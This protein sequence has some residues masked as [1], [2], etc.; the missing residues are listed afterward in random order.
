MVTAGQLA[1]LA[2]A[3]FTAEQVAAIVSALVRG[4]SAD[5]SGQI[6]ARREKDRKR[7][8]LARARVRGLS[9]DK[10]ST[11]PSLSK[12][13]I[14]LNKKVETK[15]H[16]QRD[17]KEGLG[18]KPKRAL[19]VDWTPPP[20]ALEIASEKG[21]SPLELAD[22]VAGFRDYAKG[23]DWRMADWDATFCNWIRKERRINGHHR[24]APSRNSRA[25]SFAQADAVIAEMRRREN[26]SGEANG[27]AD[28]VVFPRLREGA[29]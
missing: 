12:E 9:A 29:T 23:R 26:G 10:P 14:S 22:V 11:P 16:P 15:L 20:R 3:G 6:V 5:T 18:G 7:K 17:G 21:F 13:S 8:A 4:L 27:P 28:I 19:P 25:D 1:A 24:Q 2:E